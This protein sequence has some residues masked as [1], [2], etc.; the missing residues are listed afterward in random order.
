[1]VAYGFL[2]SPLP[3][4]VAIAK[5]IK[6]VPKREFVGDFRSLPIL[7]GIV[8]ISHQENAENEPDGD[9]ER[10]E[11]I[12]LCGAIVFLDFA[13]C[14]LLILVRLLSAHLI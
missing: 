8:I 1:M 6:G 3:S 4:L 10:D 14:D 2:H 9:D 12:Y 13:L 5:L 7:V 11:S